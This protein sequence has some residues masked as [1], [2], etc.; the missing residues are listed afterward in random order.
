MSK[1]EPVPVGVE[2]DSGS[3]FVAK[4]CSGDEES[5]WL[6]NP[7]MLS[8]CDASSLEAGAR[9][10][11]VQSQLVLQGEPDSLVYIARPCSLSPS[12]PKPKNRIQKAELTF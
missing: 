4:Q 11:R 6:L 9:E 10:Q 7:G 3:F 1:G 2:G 12:V 8:A 5:C